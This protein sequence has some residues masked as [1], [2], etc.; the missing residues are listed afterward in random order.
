MGTERPETIR[1]P[2]PSAVGIRCRS[3]EWRKPPTKKGY[4]YR[5]REVSRGSLC[6]I[7]LV[8]GGLRNVLLEHANGEEEPRDREEHHQ[9][10]LDPQDLHETSGS[11]SPRPGRL[12]AGEGG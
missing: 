4:A 5:P 12:R 6:T 7:G 10:A 3:A 8:E 9:E 11:V 2:H 1:A